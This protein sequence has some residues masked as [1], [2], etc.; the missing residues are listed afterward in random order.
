MF[1]GVCSGMRDVKIAI[2]PRPWGSVTVGADPF[3][4]VCV[5]P[6]IWERAYCQCWKRSNCAYCHIWIEQY[7]DLTCFT[8]EN[9]ES[10]QHFKLKNLSFHSSTTTNEHNTSHS[11][12]Y[13]QVYKFF[14]SCPVD[15]NSVVLTMLAMLV[16]LK[17]I[18]EKECSCENFICYL[19]FILLQSECCISHFSRLAGTAEVPSWMPFVVDK[20]WWS[21]L[22]AAL[23][24]YKYRTNIWAWR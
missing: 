10:Q 24:T 12:I 3:V 18:T 6:K 20:T 22:S 21:A 13:V 19:L 7:F 5:Q 16:W 15:T 23:T 1:T 17:K 8:E 14:F 11:G 2:R 9:T 4:D